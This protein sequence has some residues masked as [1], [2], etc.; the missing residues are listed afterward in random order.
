MTTA[1]ARHRTEVLGFVGEGVRVFETVYERREDDYWHLRKLALRPNKTIAFWHVDD[2]GGPDGVSQLK[3]DGRP[4]RLEMERLLVFTHLG[5][6]PSLLGRPTTRA[7]Y[8]PWWLIDKI[9]R[10]GAIAI[11]RHGVGIPWARYEG[12]SDTEARRVDNA[13]MGLHAN[14]KS[15]FRVDDQV[16]EWG[17]KGV[18]GTVMD[19]VPFMEYQRRDL[20]LAPLAQFLA[21]GTDGVGSLSLS[22]DHSSFFMLA[23][24]FLVT[25]IEDAYNAF[26]VPRLVGYNWSVPADRLP[27]VK[28]GTIDQRNVG[29]WAAAV[30]QVVAAGVELP[31]EELSRTAARLLGLTVP[32]EADQ[33]APDVADVND[34][35]APEVGAAAGGAANGTDQAVNQSADRPTVYGGVPVDEHLPG[36]HDQATHGKGGSSD[37]SGFSDRTKA[38]SRSHGVRSVMSSAPDAEAAQDKIDADIKRSWGDSGS[39][40]VEMAGNALMAAYFDTISPNPSGV[41]LVSIPGSRGRGTQGVMAYRPTDKG[42]DKLIALATAPGAKAGVGTRLLA[43]ASTRASDRGRGTRVDGN[44]GGARVLREGRHAAVRRTD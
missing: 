26:L 30:A 8:R 41:E 15:F 12:G 28:H 38:A 34:P 32:D 18:E 22:Q 13:L 37:V 33:P 4:E 17:I 29:E 40:H 16:T 1:L 6:G 3:P 2:T 42:P 25:E 23:L 14:E 5:D 35:N 7:M 36:Q 19:P 10:V 44:R 43:E 21:L 27:R 11:E 9:S 39:P 20:F 24:K 31:G